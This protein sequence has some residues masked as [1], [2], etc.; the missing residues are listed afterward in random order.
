M[1]TVD[2][3]WLDGS[4]DMPQLRSKSR[5]FKHKTDVQDLPEWSFD[6]GSTK[7]GDLG[8]SDRI[9]KP[10]RVYDSPFRE[11]SY[12]ALCEV[13]NPDGTAH[14]SN[15]RR[16]LAE[17]L[18]NDT[19]FGFEQEYTLTDPMMQPLVP[20]DIVQGDFYCGTGAGKIIG[21]LVAEEHLENCAKAGIDLFGINAEVMISQWEY[22]TAPKTALE[23][24]D[25]LWMAR[26]IMERGSEKFNMRISYHP[27]IYKDLNGA[28][29]HVNVST[30]EMR[31]S[32]TAIE[33][34][35][36]KL[37]KAH[38]K[39]MEVY[40]T[41]NELRLTGEC[42]TSNYNE[43]TWGVGDRGASVRI[44][45]HVKTQGKG[46]LEDRRPAATCDP[47]LVSARLLETLN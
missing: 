30:P 17:Y 1:I 14:S 44:P 34:A 43:F 27:K 39:H 25:N 10:V 4:E 32:Y 9:L 15:S 13:Y 36:P 28:G 20:E 26:Y 40:G 6:G 24:A 23:A 35:L 31:E 12:L 22:Q 46:Y 11:G 38:K 2:Y 7:Q 47:Y 41:G 5:V 16:A 45:S 18:N 19:W 37:K 3:V 21:R 8:D 29:C 42:E 33:D